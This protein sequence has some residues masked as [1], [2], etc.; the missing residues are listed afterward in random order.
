MLDKK[1]LIGVLALQGAVE[2]HCDAVTRSGGQAREV[3]YTKDME[4]CD[5]MILPGGESTGKQRTRTPQEPTNPQ[6]H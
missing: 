1:P 6:K 5:G 3:K 2:E 4:G